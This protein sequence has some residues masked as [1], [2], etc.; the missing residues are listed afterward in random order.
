MASNYSFGIKCSL[1]HVR[2]T[3][4]VQMGFFASKES[5]LPPIG[6]IIFLTGEYNLLQI[7]GKLYSYHGNILFVDRN[8]EYIPIVGI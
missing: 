4:L 6:K 8:E 2:V 5:F 1:V 3:T 7:E